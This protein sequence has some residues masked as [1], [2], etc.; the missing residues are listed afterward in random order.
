MCVF[1]ERERGERVE[2]ER[3]REGGREKTD[4]QTDRQTDKERERE[5]E[6]IS[7]G[8]DAG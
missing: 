7:H 3:G 5:R 8:N 1:A 2:Q 4:R 6:K